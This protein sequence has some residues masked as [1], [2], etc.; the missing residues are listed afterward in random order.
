MSK[1]SPLRALGLASTLLLAACGGSKEPLVIGVAGPMKAANGQSVRMAAELAVEEINR[2]GGVGGRTLELKVLDDD[3]NESRGIEVARLM[4]GDPE[5]LAVVGHVGSAVSVKAAPIYNAE[6][7]DSVAGDPLVEISPASSAPAL[8]GAGPWSF[9]VTPTDLEF[10]PALAQWAYG[11]LGSRKAAVLFVN[12]EYGQGVTSAFEAAFK[13]EGGTVVSADPYLP[14]ILTEPA[15]L[16]PYLRRA[17]TRGADAL[18]IGG[19]ADAGVFIIRAARRL[20]YQGPILG[21]DG[22]TGIKDARGVGEGVFVSSAFLPDTRAEKAQGFVAKFRGRY[23]RNPDHRAAQTYDILFMLRDAIR[24]GGADREAIRAYLEWLGREGGAPAY[25]G[26][27]GR[28]AFDEHGDVV[29]KPVII[30]VVRGGELVTA[31]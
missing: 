9:R 12:D 15:V 5:V 13:R 6:A 16:D 17:I 22:L 20:G 30:G 21:S 29:K 14:A 19:Q 10:S 1:F 18:V 2:D 24:E 28:I 26:V 8:T 25:E 7:S 23:N 11:R 4:R 3:A 31:R 27:S